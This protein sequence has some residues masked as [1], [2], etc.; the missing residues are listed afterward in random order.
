[1]IRLRESLVV[2]F[3]VCLVFWIIVKCF[4]EVESS[5]LIEVWVTI[6]L[7]KFLK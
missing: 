3:R 6:S 4:V 2:Y 7:Y 5:F 1:M